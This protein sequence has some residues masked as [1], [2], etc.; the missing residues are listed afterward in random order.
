MATR[1]VKV[2]KYIGVYFEESQ[3][4]RWH[5]KPDK[6]FWIAF[7]RGGKLV[8]ERCGWASEGWTADASQR[9]RY[10]LLEQERVGEYKPKKERKQEQ[11]T[12]GELM[13]RHYLP[14]ADENKKRARDDRSL[15]KCWLSE[16]FGNKLLND[17]SPLDLERIKKDMRSKGRAEASVK[18]ALCLVRQAFN[19]AE[20]WKLWSGE[21]PCRDITFPKPNNARQRFLS[22]EEA[23]IL[24]AALRKKSPQLSRIATF[25]LFTGL[26]LQEV[27][28]LRWSNVNLDRGIITVLDT[29][30]SESRQ[31][32]VTDRVRQVLDDIG[33][34]EPDELLFRNK[35]GRQVAWLSK[36]FKAVVDACGLNNGIH[37]P[38]EKVTFHS[39]RHTFASWAAMK[40]APLFILGRALG[41]RTTTMTA[42]YS[43]LTGDSQRSVFEAVAE[44]SAI[45]MNANGESNVG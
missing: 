31:V 35:H 18:H 45:P 3:S 44:S 26:R 42:R 7:K 32:F 34:G 21:N 17:I 2:K 37:D 9:R 27:F 10:E 22:P 24:L 11:L 6:V 43:H 40:G 29:K 36:A 33:P 15:Y 4:R 39:L 12:F 30:N 28:N 25:S 14:W 41:H 38:R 5:D 23:E 8:W 20:A 16:R 1:Y 19:K 13:G